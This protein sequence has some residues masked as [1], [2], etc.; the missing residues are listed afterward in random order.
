MTYE[1]LKNEV[2]ALGFEQSTD[3]EEFLLFAVNRAQKMIGADFPLEE[4]CTLYQSVT[5]PLIL[6]REA[7]A[8]VSLKGKC[9]I[10]FRTYAGGSLT[11]K[12][13]KGSEKYS[14]NNQ[15]LL[16]QFQLDADCE[17]VFSGIAFDLAIYEDVYESSSQIPVY[18]DMIPYSLTSDL[19][20]FLTLLDEPRDCEGAPIEGAIVEGGLLLLP[21]SYRGKVRLR[22][23]RSERAISIEEEQIDVHPAAQALLPLLSAAYLWLDDE[24]E[25]A[26]YYMTLYREG[27]ARL[28]ARLCEQTRTGYRDVLGWA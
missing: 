24:P 8:R 21:R 25:K 10:S 20:G 26:Q 22:Y 23:R 16:Y 27:A 14:F 19:A 7:P 12:S 13:Q 15:K 4:S 18:Y 17:L 3:N 5:D 28:R 11:V 1:S 2:A 6:Y 9:A